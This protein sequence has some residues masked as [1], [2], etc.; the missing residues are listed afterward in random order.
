MQAY[1]FITLFILVVAAIWGARRGFAKQLATILSLAL[2]YFVAVN[3]REPVSRMI[4]APH[5]WNLF[6]AMLG[7]FMAT[8]LLVWIGFRFVKGSLEDS[9]LKGFDTQL[10]ALFGL[11]KG[12]LLSMAIT[13]F[14]VV[15]L[16]D[17][18]RHTVLESFS[19]YNI[20]RLINSAHAIV[21]TE[22]QQAMQPYLEVIDEHQQHLAGDI[23]TS[24]PYQPPVG[25]LPPNQTP[26]FGNQPSSGVQFGTPVPS[27]QAN[28]N[29]FGQ[30]NS[31]GQQSGFFGFGNQNQQ[32]PVSNQ[33]Q[34]GFGDFREEL[35][36]QA[37]QFKQQATQAAQQRIQQEIQQ[38][39]QQFQQQV[40]QAVGDWTGFPPNTQQQ[41]P[42]Q[43]QRQPLFGPR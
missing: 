23:P 24:E 21:P 30:Q 36:N 4:E 12:L 32:A 35:A 29:G 5:P 40:E 17:A 9:G 19:G 33:P 38:R 1:D 13:M 8:S 7:L 41:N 28:Q 22:W 27:Q 14:A 25:G 43:A 34:S 20:C 2:G 15:M 11:G 42:S 31:G 37:Q 3:F 6:A 26:Q 10:G 39:G 16:G 18:Q